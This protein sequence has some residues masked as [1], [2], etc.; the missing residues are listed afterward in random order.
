M[1]APSPMRPGDPAALGPWRLRGVLGEGGMGTVYLGRDGRRVAAVKTLRREL[2]GDPHL[3]VRFRREREAAEAVHSRYVPGHLGADLGAAVPW[4]A[5]AYVPGPTLERCVEEYGPL[6]ADT[7]RALGAMLASALATLHTAGVVHRDLKPSNV[8]L[9]ADG[10]RL[11]DFGIARMPAATK[12][13]LTGQRPGSAGYMSPEQV[14][15]LELG[16]PSDVFTLGALLA[17]ACTGHHLFAGD[18]FAFADYGIAHEEPDLSRVPPSLRPALA[19]CL[20][21]AARQRPR[22]AELAA[23]WEVSGRGA[24]AGW[25]PAHVLG[26]IGRQRLR[27]RELTG[28]PGPSR[29]RVFGIAAGAAVLLGAG[30]GAAGWRWYGTGGES[31]GEV[32]LWHGA[33]GERPAPVWSVAD[34]DP[35]MPFGPVRAADVLLVADPGKVSALDPRTG[36]RLWSY[37]GGRPPVPGAAAPVLVGPDG[38]LRGLDPRTGKPAWTGPA[39]LSGLLAAESETLYARDPAGRVVAVRRGAAAPLWRSREAVASDGAVAVAQEGRLV[40]TAAD[41]AV[42]VLDPASGGAAWDTADA[43]RGLPGAVGEGLVVLGG[44]T[45]R[46]FDAKD[47]ARRWEARPTTETGSFG[48]PLVR[49]GSVYVAEGGLLRCLRLADGSDVREMTGEGG[50]YAPAQPVVAAD[51]LYVPLSAGAGGVAAFPLAGDTE[52]YRFSPG[53]ERDEPWAVAAAG[54]VV[55]AQNGGRLYALPRF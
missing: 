18:G 10:P 11:V 31:A 27:A 29:R 48:A 47:G 21:K 54:Q 14:L 44:A 28:P 51:G 36:R 38:I 4:I 49:A 16:P 5:T 12:V 17:Y 9:A 33:P 22:A 20:V 13:T 19:G 2:L 53:A 1:T 6:S 3:A 45:L 37:E 34:L 24:P 8:L 7:V 46:G 23:L 42:H 41:G 50:Q 26:E 55:A 39:G 30:A 32:P 25:L 52:R 35:R 15:G 43:A 40:V